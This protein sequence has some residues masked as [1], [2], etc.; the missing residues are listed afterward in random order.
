MGPNHHTAAYGGCTTQMRIA[1]NIGLVC[2]VLFILMDFGWN[3]R[4][5]LSEA[6][7]GSLSQPAGLGLLSYCSELFT[8]C[9]RGRLLGRHSNTNVARIS[10]EDAHLDWNQLATEI[11]DW[12]IIG[13][14]F[15]SVV[16]FQIPLAVLHAAV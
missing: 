3:G 7:E 2:V 9:C 15:A 6:Y 8:C 14:F 16:G 11:M 10:S 13:L 4:K 1:A 5:I 12:F